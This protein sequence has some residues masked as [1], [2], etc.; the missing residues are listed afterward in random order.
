MISFLM[1]NSEVKEV[2]FLRFRKVTITGKLGNE[3][4]YSIFFLLIAFGTKR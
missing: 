4:L 3:V 1:F 2:P